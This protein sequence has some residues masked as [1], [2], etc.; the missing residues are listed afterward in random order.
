[1]LC[2]SDF[3]NPV[4]FFLNGIG[5]TI[6]SLPALRALSQLFDQRLT[7]ICAQGAYELCYS[8]L[9]LRDVVP[10]ESRFQGTE[11]LF[12]VGSISKKIDKCDLF[13]SLIP[14]SS[15]SLRALKDALAPNFSVGFFSNFDLRLP[16]DFSKHSSDLLF[17]HPRL[18]D[19]SLAFE[20]FA[21][22]PCFPLEAE[23]KA[24]QLLDCIPHSIYTLAVH[25]DTSSEKMW[26]S[27]RFI[28]VLDRFFQKHHHCIAI[29][30]GTGQ[31]ELD[32]GRY[33]KRVIPCY[34]LPLDVSMCLVAKANL[35]LGIDSC[36]LHIAD[37][38][39][40]P[41]VGLFGPTSCTEF[42]FR[43]G[44][45]RHVCAN[46]AMDGI[47][48]EPVLAALEALYAES[49]GAESHSSKGTDACGSRCGLCHA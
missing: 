32:R 10:I 18:F 23:T 42:G 36:M 29:V 19:D 46:G 2:P 44:P 49:F 16:K 12:D 47:Q 4:A 35:F 30:V 34:G 6:L 21:S 22:P 14:W 39:R 13:L 17:D 37:F 1:M 31:T 48:I 41:G 28:T 38:N 9:P 27:S 11:C 3:Q 20:D 40:V 25:I 7:L 8:E 43:L 15:M 24:R 5:D 26:P 45:H 33:G